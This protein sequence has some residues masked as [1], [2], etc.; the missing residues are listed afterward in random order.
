MQVVFTDH[1]L[2]G[3]ADASS[4][5]TNKVLKFSLADVHEVQH[6]QPPNLLSQSVTIAASC[7]SAVHVEPHD[8]LTQP[9]RAPACPKTVTDAL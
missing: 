4:I 8:S 3:F 1:S 7:S 6:T 9:R 5:L 2:F